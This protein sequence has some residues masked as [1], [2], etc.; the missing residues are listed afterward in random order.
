MLPGSTIL[1]GLEL[2]TTSTTPPVPSLSLTTSDKLHRHCLDQ[3][4][5]TLLLKPFPDGSTAIFLF[6]KAATWQTDATLFWEHFKLSGSSFEDPIPQLVVNC[7][8]VPSDSS[9]GIICRRFHC[10]ALLKKTCTKRAVRA[11]ANVIHAANILPGRSIKDLRKNMGELLRAG[12]R[13]SLLVKRFGIGCLVVLG[14]HT[15]RSTYVL[16]HGEVCYVNHGTDGRG[17]SLQRAKC[18]MTS[19]ANSRPRVFARKQDLGQILATNFFN[20]SSRVSLQSNLKS[21]S[22]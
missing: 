19:F 17:T 5:L 10:V 14:Q 12:E 22:C 9:H 7:L 20:R 4:L 15:A 16:E 3:R 2:G 13:Y 6:N 21:Q 11:V 1:P 18:A 8:L